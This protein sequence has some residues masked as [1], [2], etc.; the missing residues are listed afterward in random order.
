VQAR[1]SGDA[2]R[3][4]NDAAASGV[5]GTVAI[6][7]KPAAPVLPTD[8]L[9]ALLEAGGLTTLLLLLLSLA[10]LAVAVTKLFAFAGVRGR[11]PEQLT[12]R[13]VRA[14]AEGDFRSAREACRH[15]EASFLG[16]RRRV[17]LADVYAS[18]LE[19][20]SDPG[21]ALREAAYAR[22]DRETLKLER[23]L[24]FL[25]TMGSVSPFI[26]LFGT[27]VGVIRAFAA[28]GAG[29]DTGTAAGLQPV[30]AG[31]AEALVATAAGLFVAVPAVIFYNAFVRALKRQQALGEQG[32]AVLCA[33]L[34]GRTAP[35]TH[36]TLSP[37]PY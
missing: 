22:L 12:D 35:P 24:G 18:V 29:A 2:H 32:L 33:E 7:R 20:T 19:T 31:I 17:P 16:A 27:V 4:Q 13:V 34:E 15:A 28:L 8:N 14:A 3:A 9:F 1:I 37:L 25:S 21:P 26:G 6:F 23:G 10:S 11:A 36:A 5:T 30:M